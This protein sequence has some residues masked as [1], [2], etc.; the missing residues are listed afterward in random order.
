MDK[1]QPTTCQIAQLA[2]I[3]KMTVHTK[4]LSCGRSGDEAIEIVNILTSLHRSFSGQYKSSVPFHKKFTKLCEDISCSLGWKACSTVVSMSES[5]VWTVSNARSIPSILGWGSLNLG[6]DLLSLFPARYLLKRMRVPAFLLESPSFVSLAAVYFCFIFLHIVSA[7][8]A[9]PLVASGTAFYASPSA[10][11]TLSSLGPQHRAITVTASVIRGAAIADRLTVSVNVTTIFSRNFAIVQSKMQSRTV[12]ILFPTR[13]TESVFFDI[14]ECNVTT[15]DTVELRVTLPSSFERVRL[16]WF[17]C[18]PIARDY[19]RVAH[20]TMSLLVI[21]AAVVALTLSGCVLATLAFISLFVPDVAMALY[22]TAFRLFALAQ[23]L[24]PGKRKVV[25][26]GVAA[27]A[28]GM[29]KF[30]WFTMVAVVSVAVSLDGRK[31]VFAG[32]ALMDVVAVWAVVVGR[33]ASEWFERSVLPQIIE[34][35]VPMTS[36]AFALL[37][38][39]VGEIKE[40]QQMGNIE[41]EV[42]SG[43]PAEK[44]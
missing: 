42:L 8:M 3:I 15:F 23:L 21:Y 11:M 41:D 26:L 20:C 36:G 35:V 13:S 14:F 1:I 32:F 4:N 34:A 6:L 2:A 16:R 17:Y 22:I 9:P 27:V 10:T 25:A 28:L 29:S 44:L 30:E 5:S 19:I 12:H 31:F 43:S 39:R 18:D 40:Y 37:A 38:I 24:P 7:L 33:A